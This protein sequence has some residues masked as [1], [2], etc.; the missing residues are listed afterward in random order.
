MKN[1]TV[2]NVWMP[3]NITEWNDITIS[4]NHFSNSGRNDIQVSGP[5]TGTVSITGNTLDGAG[6]RTIRLNNLTGGVTITGNTITNCVGRTTDTLTS[7]MH[8]SAA[9]DDT[10]VYLSGNSWNGDT[11]EQAT[12]DKLI[13]DSPAVVTVEND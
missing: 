13:I 4:N 11:D 6:E 12:V 9:G 8:F 3:I 10:T 5:S 1:C 2:D 7:L